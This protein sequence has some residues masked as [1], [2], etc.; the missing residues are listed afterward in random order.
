MLQG[1]LIVSHDVMSS[2]YITLVEHEKIAVVLL[3]WKQ[4]M[5]CG[6]KSIEKCHVKHSIWHRH[7]FM[8][9]RERATGKISPQETKIAYWDCI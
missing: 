9:A 6:K 5:S 8:T 3:Q 4:T 1:F 2:I 7:K